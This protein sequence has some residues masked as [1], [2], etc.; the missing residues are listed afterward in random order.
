MKPSLTLARQGVLPDTLIESLFLLTKTK[1]QFSLSPTSRQHLLDAK[2][3]LT[4][5]I[6][7]GLGLLAAPFAVFEPDAI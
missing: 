1:I 7:D 2:M 5:G 6:A 4:D 3:Y